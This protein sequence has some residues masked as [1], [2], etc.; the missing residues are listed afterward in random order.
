MSSTTAASPTL[1]DHGHAHPHDRSALLKLAF[2]A[3]GVVY[4]DIGTSP[5]YALRECFH[6][7]GV[8]EENAATAAAQIPHA[9]VLGILSLATWALI[10]IVVIKYLTFALRAD[11]HGEGGILALLSLLT[12]SGAFRPGAGGVGRKRRIVWLGLIAAAL[13]LADGMITPAIS[14]LSAVE[15]LKVAAPSIES[16]VVPITVGILFGLFWVQKYGTAHIA[17]FF[18]PMMLVWFLSIGLLGIPA[19]AHTPSVLLALL[20]TYA[21]HL[22]ISDPVH[23]F[24]MLG[25]VVLVVTGAEA[26]YA[27][28]GH[29]GRGPIRLAWYSLVFPALLLNY[30]G[31][32]AIVLADPAAAENPFWHIVPKVLQ[33]PMVGIATIATIIA[34]QAL[35]SGA[36]SLAQQAM[37]LG[38]APRL[39]VIHTSA[40]VVGQIFVPFIN[41]TLMVMYITLVLIFRDSSRLANMYGMA[42]TGTMTITSILLFMVAREKWLWPFWKAASFTTL[43]LIVDLLFFASNLTKF[44]EGGW[45]AL[46]M[47]G[48]IFLVMANWYIGRAVIAAPIYQLSQNL[49]SFLTSIK[50]DPPL[51]VSG[52]AIFMTTRPGVVPAVL[53]HHLRHN[54]VL[55]ERIILLN[56]RTLGVPVV[57]D[58]DRCKLSE[59]GAGF[60]EVTL[61]FGFTEEP[62]VPLH[63]KKVQQLGLHVDLDTVSYFLGHVTL[64]ITNRG[65]MP[66][67]FRALF[68]FLY[69]NE[70]PVTEFFNLPVN[71]VIE[72]GR[73][74]EL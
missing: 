9:E 56:V 62:D 57:R 52:T 36:F 25:A 64:R 29:F 54:R 28:M 13:L 46:L 68:G 2:G 5:L 21:V 12:G 23:A 48:A 32:G 63:M 33:Y 71:R 16:L 41:F 50:R 45:V 3:L 60:Y 17:R 40:E 65:R 8:T 74:A 11:N 26:L 10:I 67:W 59:A 58:E 6:Q 27:D 44:A 4:G 42:V 24:F 14:V 7:L 18:G 53:L 22:F 61:Q 73:Q 72:L 38:Y 69:H 66:R 1:L 20:P 34:S 30:Y 15:G 51:R 35:I 49:G 39:Q 43:L 37:Q 47:A 70:R 19:I 31:Q 55:H